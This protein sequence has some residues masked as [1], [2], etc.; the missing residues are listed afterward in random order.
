MISKIKKFLELNNYKYIYKDQELIITI[1]FQQEVVISVS[2]NS[3]SI[4]DRLKIGNPISGM[5][6]YSL[7]ISLFVNSALLVLGFFLKEMY[8]FG[9]SLI[10]VCLFFM[11]WYFYYLIKLE[12][13]KIM[14]NNCLTKV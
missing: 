4:K 10:L 8:N 12:S 5:L 7:R 3:I 6:S 14:V 11:I 1:S 9:N 13:F 2:E